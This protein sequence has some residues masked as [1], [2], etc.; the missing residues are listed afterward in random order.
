MTL[1]RGRVVELE[2]CAVL[3]TWAFTLACLLVQPLLARADRCLGACWVGS[4]GVAMGVVET[5]AFFLV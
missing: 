1:A 5:Q 2:V 4:N 3:L